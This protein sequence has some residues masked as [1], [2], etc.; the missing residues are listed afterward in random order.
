M[1]SFSLYLLLLKLWDTLYALRSIKRSLQS[2]ER[3]KK[4]PSFSCFTFMFNNHWKN[5]VH[6]RLVGFFSHNISFSTIDFVSLVTRAISLCL[7]GGHNSTLY[8]ALLDKLRNQRDWILSLCFFGFL[9]SGATH[10]S[11]ALVV[12]FLDPFL[13]VQFK[14][15]HLSVFPGLSRFQLGFGSLQL[16]VGF[17]V[18]LVFFYVLFWG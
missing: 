16:F 13:Q 5:L 14:S 18:W 7:V 17:C 15:L 6:P 8:F 10:T 11:P 3:K 9:F 12:P 4:N 1:V 2:Q